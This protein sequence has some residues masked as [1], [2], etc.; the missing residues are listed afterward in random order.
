MSSFSRC[1][2]SRDYGAGSVFAGGPRK[3]TATGART[4]RPVRSGD[5]PQRSADEYYFAQ[6]KKGS[7]PGL[8]KKMAEEDVLVSGS[9]DTLRLV[10]HFNFKREQVERVAT[11]FSRALQAS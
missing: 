8:V 4:G 3:R 6:V 9:Y 10:T 5:R 7:L 2:D 1:R 11:A